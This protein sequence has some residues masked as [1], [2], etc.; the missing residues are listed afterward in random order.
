MKYVVSIA[1]LLVGSVYYFDRII[2]EGVCHPMMRSLI[3]Y[4]LLANGK[5]RMNHA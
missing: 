5:H 1:L 2:G 4:Y 3:G